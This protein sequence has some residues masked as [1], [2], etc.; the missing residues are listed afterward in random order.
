MM[1]QS[2]EKS[3]NIK[4]TIGSTNK[5][6]DKQI[7]RTDYVLQRYSDRWSN[8]MKSNL[9]SDILQDNPI[10]SLIFAEQ[11]VNG[12]EIIWLLDGK[13]RTTTAYSFAQN[14]FKISK[15][16]RRFMIEYYV[17]VLDEN[18]NIVRDDNGFPTYEC[19]QCDIRG[20]FFSD[21]PEE[22]QDKFLDYSFEIVKYLN[23]S[24]EDIAYHMQRY[25]EGCPAN[26]AEKGIFKIGE[27]YAECVK[28][29]S[30]KCFF[31]DN[32]KTE[33]YN[34]KANRIIIEAIMLS[35]FKNDWNS[36]Y[37]KICEFINENATFD[38]FYHFEDLVERLNNC[39]N[40]DSI[41]FLFNSK[42]K[43]NLSL[44]LALFSKFDNL[45]LSDDNFDE[46][47]QAFN[48]KLHFKKINGVSFDDLMEN[49]S[50]KDKNPTIKRIDFLIQ[51]M[52]DFFGVAVKTVE[53]E[54]ITDDDYEE[55]A[56]NFVSDDVAA[57]CLAS[58]K[59]C[60]DEVF[61]SET[62]KTIV[63]WCKSECIPKDLDKCLN[64]KSIII[65]AGIDEWDENLP[66]YIYGVKY[67]LDQ[68]PEIEISGWIASAK[69]NDITDRTFV[70]DSATKYI[71]KKVINVDER[72]VA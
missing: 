50:T 71:N 70:K 33:L 13:Q 18:H 7:L 41:E 23:C 52:A 25:N 17:P 21:L 6:I 4:L 24:A 48:E 16:I 62:P 22:L 28:A 36:S 54:D 72:S 47:I 3:K 61:N 10:P 15:N 55:F 59:D 42:N 69:E 64:Y 9:I 34:G 45:K 49:K 39:L 12:M 46:F 43:K 67:I 32:F 26:V 11:I 5:K 1:S 53:G 20:K 38:Q 35:N 56:M 40:A 51:L 27:R 31:K 19:K 65:N 14:G 58:T 60:P 37:D 68:H 8:L 2:M 30:N 66:Y 57:K 63:E 29:I 44:W